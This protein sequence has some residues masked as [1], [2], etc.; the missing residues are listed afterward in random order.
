MN[1][2]SIIA[3]G[4]STTN[5]MDLGSAVVVAHKALL[6]PVDLRIQTVVSSRC[7]QDQ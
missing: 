6:T 5:L 2:K 3:L 4:P 1:L 7:S